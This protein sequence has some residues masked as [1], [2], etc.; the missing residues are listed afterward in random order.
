MSMNSNKDDGGALFFIVVLFFMVFVSAIL[1]RACD[2]AEEAV[3]A[4][5][6]PQ[7]SQSAPK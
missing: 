1:S 3:K 5:N 6:Q 4:L 7:P 2:I